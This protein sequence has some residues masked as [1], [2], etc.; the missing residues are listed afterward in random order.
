MKL[1]VYCDSTKTNK[2][3]CIPVML[4]VKNDKGRFLINTGLTTTEKFTGREFPKSEKNRTAKTSA[5]GR[6]LLKVEEICLLNSELDNNKLKEKINSEVFSKG[7]AKGRTLA[8]YIKQYADGMVNRGTS[9]VYLRTAHR[10]MLFDD[11]ATF[12]SVDR[13][14]LENYKSHYSKTLKTNTISIDLRNIRTVFNR[15]IDDEITIKYPF[16]KFKIASERVIIRNLDAQQIAQ[17]RGCEVS[18][19]LEIYR[20]LFMLDFYLCGVNAIDLLMCKGLTNGRFVGKRA[21]TGAMIDLPVEKEAM[22]IINK[23]K[24]ES[25]LLS[26]MDN[27]SDYR[28]FERIWND[29]LKKIGKEE[30]VKDKV[31]KLRKIIYHPLFG[32][33]FQMTT[34]VAR[35]SFASIAASI[36]IDRETIAL[37]LSHS[38]ADVTD[39]YIN[40][41]RSRVD[42]AVRAV[43]KHVN[44]IKTIDNK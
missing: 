44:G 35:Y 12:D 28:S 23:Y 30:K 13:N 20:D 14:W 43:I 18:S 16:R 26:P 34:Y 5:L 4:I 2:D 1:Y 25:Y 24:G 22:D 29:N 9:E 31:G 40:Y 21:K 3:G 10:V 7:S 33:D 27:R 39:H 19:W 36:G 6:Y 38:W 42:K 37:C 17:F 8:H 41:D 15:A 32:K 11:T